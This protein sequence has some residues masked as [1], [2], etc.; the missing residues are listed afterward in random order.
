MADTVVSDAVRFPQDEGVGSISDGNESWDSAGYLGGLADAIGS[1]TFVYSGLTFSNHDATN[2]TISVESGRAYVRI[3]APDVQSLTGGTTAPSY[4]TTLNDGVFVMLEM[5][6]SEAS[7]PLQDA[8]LSAV[9]LA[10]ATD[11]TISGVSPGDIYIRSDDTGSI[12]APPHPSVKLGESNPDD[13]TA[14]T[15]A[16]DR[17]QADDLDLSNA[18]LVNDLDGNNNS[19]YSLTEVNGGSFSS[20]TYESIFRVYRNGNLIGYLDNGNNNVRLKAFDS[21]ANAEML[22][23]NSNGIKVLP[24]GNGGDFTTDGTMTRTVPTD[25]FEIMLEH[26]RNGARVGYIDNSGSDFR[27]KADNGGDAEIINDASEGMKIRGATANADFDGDLEI[28]T[29]AQ[30]NND[31]GEAYLEFDED[32]GVADTATSTLF[33]GTHKGLVVVTTN[34][35]DMGIFLFVNSSVK[36]I[37]TGG[38]NGFSTTSGNAGTNNVYHNGTNYVVENQVG[39]TVDYDAVGIGRQ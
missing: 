14:D 32:D 22:N 34:Q 18:K 36:S 31:F 2:D 27:F 1:N 30:L 9:W 25:S 5:P 20:D 19:I 24:E 10:Y 35:D 12:A 38:P 7:I 16:S 23:S 37:S 33:A 17:P 11:D 21:A 3:S 6:T 4:D 13:A 29:G 28:D 15:R 26:Q 39:V 8:A